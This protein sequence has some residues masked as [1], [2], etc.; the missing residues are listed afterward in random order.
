MNL[1]DFLKSKVP[2]SLLTYCLVCVFGIGSWMAVNGIWAEI[3]ILLNST[4]ECYDLPATLVVIIQIANIGILLY[5]LVKYCFHLCKLQA[6][7]AH[8]EVGTIL[9]LIL[10]G[11]SSCILLAIFWNRTLFVFGKVR[12]VSLFMLSFFLALVDCMSSVLF[13]PFMKHFPPEYLSALYIGEGLSGLLPSLF[14]FSQGSVNNSILC[15]NSYIG[16]EALGIRFSP[17]VYFIFLGGLMSLSGVSF[18]AL[19]TLPAVRRH[20]VNDTWKQSGTSIQQQNHKDDCDLLRNTKMDDGKDESDE[21]VPF[22]GV[23]ET[24]EPQQNKLYY[25][26]MDL[27]RIVWSNAALYLCLSVLSFLTNSALSAVSSFVFRP[28]ENSIYHISI[29]LAL[30]ANPLMSL[31]FFVFPSRSKVIAV[32]TTVIICVLGIYVLVMAQYPAPTFQT[33]TFGKVLIVSH[34]LQ[35]TNYVYSE[36]VNRIVGN[37]N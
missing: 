23:K 13:I 15:G 35:A 29:N 1:V 8:L 7:Q 32:V 5:V 2:K 6:Y 27:C 3:A 20:M 16:H 17:N 22:S 31:F 24:E 37:S 36:A 11:I 33:S 30:I 26:I 4:P 9:I 18:V 28:Y 25:I 34:T 10:T 14:A 12:S 21:I 19:V